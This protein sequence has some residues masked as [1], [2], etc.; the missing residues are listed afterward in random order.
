[1]SKYFNME[2]PLH[3][4][5]FFILAVIL[6]VFAMRAQVGMEIA[7]DAAF[8]LRYAENMLQGEFWV[9]NPGEAPV[10]GASAP[11]HPLVIALVMKFG[12]S[13]V[14]ALVGAGIGMSAIALSLTALVLARRVGL[15]AGLSFVALSAFDT[16]TMYFVGAGLET[17]LTFL[18]LAL[19]VWSLLGTPRAWMVGVV[20]GLLIVN[21]LDLVPV[22][23]LLLA[24][25][26]LREGRFP[27]RAVIVAAAIALAWYGFAWVYFGAPVPNSFLTKIL[28]Q[29]NHPRV[30]DWTWFGKTVF[31]GNHLW[32]AG[33]AVAACLLLCRRRLPLLIFLCASLAAHVLAYTLKYPFEPYNWYAM[34]A[35]FALFALAAMGMQAVS[36][37]VGA[38]AGRFAPALSIG[39]PALVLL[40]IFFFGIPRERALTKLYKTYNAHQEYDRAEAGR[41]VAANTP[42]DFRVLTCWGNPAYYSR[43]HVIDCSF[44]NRKYEEG[45]VVARYEPEIVIMQSTSQPSPAFAKDYVVIKVFDKTAK[46]GGDYSFLVIAR[47]DVLDRVSNSEPLRDLMSYVG[48]IE[49][50]DQFGTVHAQGLSLFV[51]P[52]LTTPT[53][54]AF[55]LNKFA[56]ASGQETAAVTISMAP[57]IPEDAIRRGAGNVSARIISGDAVL[58]AAV[59]TTNAPQTA[60]IDVDGNA[61]LTIVIDNN[62]NPDTDWVLVS[63]K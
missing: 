29:Q 35:V 19:A 26:W 33:L 49:A 55:D 48:E 42:R 54:F 62:G 59:V 57:N 37:L 50:G 15:V 43:R 41:W 16:E 21:K 56:K 24:A 32:S 28:H 58:H 30:I 36:G 38:R 3:R 12:V 53:R 4:L 44:L 11:L 9:W 40:S 5:F 27:V 51:H 39:V 60:V 22:G 23:G 45:D 61:K 20:A 7:D 46:A 34:P 47:E 25:H 2:S 6:Y 14:S 10:W 31:L 63:V 8:F 13:P 17:P 52:G 18:L 1:M